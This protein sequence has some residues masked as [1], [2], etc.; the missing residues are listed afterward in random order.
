MVSDV[1]GAKII[2]GEI[3]SDSYLGFG[4]PNL[5]YTGKY[6]GDDQ[7]I[8]SFDFTG[9]TVYA[10]FGAVYRN[11]YGDYST[12]Q[13]LREGESY[14]DALS[15]P[16]ERWGD[17]SGAQRKYNEPGKCWAFGIYGIPNHKYGNWIAEM[18]SPDSLP[19]AAV[20]QPAETNIKANVYPNPSADFVTVSFSLT[21]THEVTITIAGINGT[22][23]TQ[24][25]CDTL[26]SGS[27]SFSFSATPLPEGIYAV[28][29]DI[30]GELPVTKKFEVVR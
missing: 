26:R 23:V 4:Y 19:P 24:L 29:I 1:S 28:R 11:R 8:I 25:M 2:T 16:Y 22:R 18:M 17:Y 13:V 6:P 21:E 15:G 3:I 14:I 9:D 5:S 20:Y 12:L 27:Y 7:W 30:S 10:G